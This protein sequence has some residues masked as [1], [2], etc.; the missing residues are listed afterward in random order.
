[1]VLR[2]NQWVH[3]KRVSDNESSLPLNSNPTPNTEVNIKK[4]TKKRPVY[5]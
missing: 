3:L 2:E 4:S 5:K 1:M